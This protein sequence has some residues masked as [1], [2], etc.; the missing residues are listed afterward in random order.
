MANIAA[1]VAILA[2]RCHACAPS[3]ASRAS[4]PRRRRSGT[5]RSA[6]RSWIDGF[7][8]LRKLEGDWPAVGSRAVWDSQPGGR[9][10]VVEHVTAYEAR[11]GQTV[12]VED[13]Q[14]RGTQRVAFEPGPTAV[15]VSLELEYELKG[16][17]CS[18]RSPTRSSSAA[19]C[20]SRSRG[21]WPRFARERR[22][23]HGAGLLIRPS[24]ADAECELMRRI[25]LTIRALVLLPL[26]AVLTDQTRAAVLCEPGAESCLEA[27]G[28]GW[29]AARRAARARALRRRAGAASSP[30]W[31]AP[32][33]ASGACGRSPPARS[34]P[35]APPRPGSPRCSA[36]APRSAAAGSGC[37]RWA[38]SRAPCS[39]S[40][41][42]SRPSWFARCGRPR[43]ACIS[44]AAVASRPLERSWMGTSAA[45]LRLT[46]GRA[47]PVVA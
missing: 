9:G 32:H 7:G 44:F 10:R 43:R 42:G 31:P 41:C 45:R 38:S 12:A 47:P 26:L 34:G 46:R 23:G 11:V 16:A 25:P 4:P 17:T 13:E 33:P 39:R 35:P 20:A 5:T 36:R 22:G 28:Q 1:K 21:R 8:H 24:S 14:L 2:P 6:G 27:A 19:R 15:E 3:S 40:R 29:Y 37:W 18:R 30:A